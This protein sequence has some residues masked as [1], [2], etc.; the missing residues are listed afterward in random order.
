MNMKISI[1]LLLAVLLFLLLGASCSSRDDEAVKRLLELESPTYGESKVSDAR[2]EELKKEIRTYRGI[3]EEKVKANEK[4]GTFYKLLAIAYID[5]RM[6]GEALESIESAIRIYPEQ[7]PLFLYKAIAA[8]RLSKAIMDKKEKAELLETAE[9]SYLRCIDL[10]PL[11][12]GGLYGLAVLY[13]FE[14]NRPNEAIPL[15]QK[16]LVKQKQNVEALFLLARVYVAVGY[17]EDALSTYDRIIDT[18]SAGTLREEARKN[19]KLILE[20]AVK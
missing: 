6:F 18:P 17:V 11:S 10:D 20:G 3:V 16:I 2:I 8:G 9:T 1:S 14:L 19:K 7:A 13:A 4:L 15:L 5:R 12:V